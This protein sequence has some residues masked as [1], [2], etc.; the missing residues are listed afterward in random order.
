MSEAIAITVSLLAL[1]F[2]GFTFFW[3][4][5]TRVRMKLWIPPRNP[6]FIALEGEDEPYISIINYSP[7]DVSIRRLFYRGKVDPKNSFDFPVASLCANID[8]F[9]KTIEARRSHRVQLDP[10]ELSGLHKFDGQLI[11]ELDT[12][13]LIKLGRTDRRKLNTYMDTVVRPAYER[14]EAIFDSMSKVAKK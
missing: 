4:D 10:S 7:F 2:S 12:L 1:A 11:A 14:S 6:E 5:T 9:P 3:R 13:K 8:S